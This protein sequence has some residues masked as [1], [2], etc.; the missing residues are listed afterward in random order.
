MPCNNNIKPYGIIIGFVL[1]FLSTT[2]T[3]ADLAGD[4]AKNPEA[5]REDYNAAMS[6]CNG[7]RGPKRIERCIEKLNRGYR[8]H[9][10]SW[11]ATPASTSN[12]SSTSSSID[13]SALQTELTTT[14]QA[15]IEMEQQLASAQETSASATATQ[16]GLQQSLT[17]L[18]SQL[19]QAMQEKTGLQQQLASVQETAASATTEQ[20]ALEQQ[21]DSLQNQLSSSMLQVSNLEGMLAD[22]SPAGNEQQLA[23]CQGQLSASMLLV[24]DLESQ[25]DRCMHPEMHSSP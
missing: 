4:V 18:E 23:S 20:Q 6:F 12:D 11:L 8:R 3:Y 19:Q 21:L 16:Q 7:E 17:S 13:F 24:S 14:K 10:D 22:T 15:L 25:F 5:T 2:T 9:G 1:F